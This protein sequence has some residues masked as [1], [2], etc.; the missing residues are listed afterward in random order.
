VEKEEPAVP[1]DLT[2]AARRTAGLLASIP[3]EA[4]DTPT[5]CEKYTLGDLIHHLD[6]LALAFTWAAEKDPKTALSAGGAAGDAEQLEAG[7]RE[8]IPERLDVLAKVWQN[9]AA[10][11][12]M[13]AAGGADLP[14]EV[15]GLVALNEVVVHGWDI[16]RAAGLPYEISQEE[17]DACLAFVSQVPRDSETQRT[18]FGPPVSV[19][20][21]APPIDRVIGANGR[22]P[23][24]TPER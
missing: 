5:P 12:G 14:G 16:A 17:S 18:G 7:W 21:E 15:A 2:P 10:W 11:T 9:P 1:I 24:W 19:P 4:L 20:D 23:R 13:T 6:G 8:R 3:D 22:D